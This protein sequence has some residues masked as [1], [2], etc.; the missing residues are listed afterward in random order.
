M[1]DKNIRRVKTTRD[2]VKIAETISASIIKSRLSA[3]VRL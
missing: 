1:K 3:C 2:N